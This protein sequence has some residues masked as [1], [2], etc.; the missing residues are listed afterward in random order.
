MHCCTRFFILL[1]VTTIMISSNGC[2]QKTKGS[3]YDIYEVIN[4]FQQFNDCG[5]A[6]VVRDLKRVV[7]YESDSLPPP[8]PG[9]M[10]YSRSTFIGLFE[11]GL[12]DSADMEYMYR[13]I[14]SLAPF[15]LD[16]ALIDGLSIS[17]R[18]LDGLIKSDYTDSLLVSKYNTSN[19]M[20]VSRPVFSADRTKMLLDI[21]YFCRPDRSTGTTYFLV[22]KNGKWKVALSYGKWM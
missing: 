6:V 1:L 8:P 5:E 9:V 17:E 19:L 12:I 10:Y 3:G 20:L 4:G 16:S 15:S 11:K 21:D 22:K 14:D 18:E 2:S 13:K 7:K